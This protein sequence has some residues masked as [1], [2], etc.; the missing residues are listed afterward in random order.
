MVRILLCVNF[1][2]WMECYIAVVFI[3]RLEL[4]LRI[5]FVF[6]K[7][8]NKGL[9]FNIIFLIRCKIIKIKIKIMI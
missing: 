6:S 1:K 2:F 5:V 3:K 8:F 7:V 9:D 4:L